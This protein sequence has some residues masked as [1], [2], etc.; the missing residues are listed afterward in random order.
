MAESNPHQSDERFKALADR[1]SFLIW[2]AG[3]DG[4]RMYFNR[5]WLDF[6]GQTLEHQTGSGWLNTV[7]P[8]DRA[9]CEKANAQA[10]AAR[11]PLRRE[12][13]L[14]RADGEYRWILE[15]GVPWRDADGE[16]A[17]LIGSCTD[18]TDQRQ[19]DTELKRS[20]SRLEEE[21]ARERLRGR[22][23]DHRV[24]SCLNGLLGLIGA[25]EKSGRDAGALAAAVRRH[26]A[27]MGDAHE[28]IAG[29]G[30]GPADLGRMI[31]RLA[32][33]LPA[34]VATIGGPAALVPSSRAVAMA[35][36]LQ[37]LFANS[38]THGV[39]RP[40][41][42]GPGGEAGPGRLRVSWGL[43][44][45]ATT[46]RLELVWEEAWG[47]D[48]WYGKVR[49]ERPARFGVG[50]ELVEGIARSD[51]GGDIEAKVGANGYRCV[52]RAVFEDGYADQAPEVVVTT[53][54]KSQRTG[55]KG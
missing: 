12:Y 34:G 28:L 7:H 53:T 16:F 39:L 38:R 40:G 25:Y 44:V 13:R 48:E 46:R 18:T 6:T 42:A 31:S 27:A 11:T 10:V 21:L 9:E 4:G 49:A 22:E 24:R 32:G 3:P 33:E 14:R 19:P 47:E 8:D 41:G 45:A 37:E 35:M 17:G 2:L 55:A 50:L 20:V 51:L 30:G 54:G 5:A 43:D 36:V 23:L 52:L 29:A 1:A 26:V 15:S